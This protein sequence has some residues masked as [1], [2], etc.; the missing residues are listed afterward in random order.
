MQRFAYIASSAAGF[1]PIPL[2]RL[3]ARLCYGAASFVISNV[4]AAA[5]RADP[6][7]DLGTAIERTRLR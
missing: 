6:P 4:A 5:V 7:I 3:R 2:S 1:A